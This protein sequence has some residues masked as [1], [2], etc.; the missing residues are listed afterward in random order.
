MIVPCLA[1]GG[2]M[3]EALECFT[4]SIKSIADMLPPDPRKDFKV[5]VLPTHGITH[6]TINQLFRAFLVKLSVAESVLAP[7]PAHFDTTFSVLI[8]TNR[9]V[10][11]EDIDYKEMYFEDDPEAFKAHCDVPFPWLLADTEQQS[12][13]DNGLIIPLKSISNEVIRMQL[14]VQEGSAKTRIVQDT[15]NKVASHEKCKIV[16]EDAN[17]KNPINKA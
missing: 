11:P 14:W 1:D 10:N 12:A 16:K 8:K 9:Q 4:I 3:R 6:S 5:K 2:V 15:D 7:I 13:L 17:G